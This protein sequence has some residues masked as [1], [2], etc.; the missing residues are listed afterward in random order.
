[1]DTQHQTA[2]RTLAASVAAR[3]RAVDTATDADVALRHRA[4]ACATVS[5][6]LRLSVILGFGAGSLELRALEA[7]ADLLW[8]GDD[9][10]AH[11]L[12][13]GLATGTLDESHL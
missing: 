10:E 8:D 1:M 5:T 6:V 4:D 9:P 11:G 12:L 7:A 13:D 2:A 3:L